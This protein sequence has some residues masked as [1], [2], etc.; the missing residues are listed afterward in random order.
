M[1]TNKFCSEL[2]INFLS[3]QHEK[4]W[5]CELPNIRESVLLYIYAAD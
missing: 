1:S 2:S 4:L 3:V 5:S